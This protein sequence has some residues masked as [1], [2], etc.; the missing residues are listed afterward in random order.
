MI[1]HLTYTTLAEFPTFR[2]RTGPLGRVIATPLDS[3]D[4]LASALR[5]RDGWAVTNWRGKHPHQICV[6]DYDE[7]IA[8]LEAVAKVVSR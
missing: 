2:L 5:G 7:A 6:S 4:E 3:D 8:V 1:T